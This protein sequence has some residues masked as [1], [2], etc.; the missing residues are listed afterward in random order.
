MGLQYLPEP[1]WIDF[2][3]PEGQICLLSDDNSPLTARLAQTLSDRSWPVVVLSFFDSLSPF[4]SLPAKINRIAIEDLSEIHLQEQLEAIST[5]YGSIAAMIHLHPLFQNPEKEHNILEKVFFLAKYL[6]KSLNQAAVQGNSCFFNVAH[7]DGQLGVS[8]KED[9]AIA[10]E[11]LNKT[12]Y[13]LKKQH[14]QS[15]IVAIN[16][17]PWDSGMVS[18]ELKRVFA[19]RNISTIPIDIGTQMLLEELAPV[20]RE[21]VQVIIGSPLKPPAITVS[22][23][24]NYQIHRRLSLAANQFLHDHVIMERPVL[25]ATCAIGWIANTCEQIYPGYQFFGCDDF[26]VLKGIIFDQNLADKYI[27]DLEKKAVDNFEKIEINA[28]IWSKHTDKSRYHFNT[29]LKLVKQVSERPYYGLLNL[30]SEKNAFSQ[31][32]FIYQNGKKVCFMVL[33]FRELK[34]F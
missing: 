4:N 13:I 16:W 8:G 7:L 1:D 29:K 28:K 12:A 23:R 22:S 17:G 18:P 31:T 9:N 19:E 2:R 10:N 21:T 30:I 11:I 20:N 27:L 34:K 5:K 3:L 15:H 6:K 26:Q 25:P 32:E 33:L 24:S 14:P